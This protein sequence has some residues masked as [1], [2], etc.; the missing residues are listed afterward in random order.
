MIGMILTEAQLSVD[1]SWIEADYKT[2][3]MYLTA[4]LIATDNTDEGDSVN[5]GGANTGAIASESFGAISVSYESSAGSVKASALND[6][7]GGTSY[8]RRFLAMLR[9]NKPGI[10]VV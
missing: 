8:G 2:A 4:H 10:L 5:I 9:R 1:Q 3:I 6:L 7:Y